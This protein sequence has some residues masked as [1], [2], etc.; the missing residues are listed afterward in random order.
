M[1]EIKLVLNVQLIKIVRCSFLVDLFILSIIYIT[2][3][4]TTLIENFSGWLV[5][6]VYSNGRKFT[7]VEELKV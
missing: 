4:A 5:R 6:T 3:F 2:L 1:F 7:T